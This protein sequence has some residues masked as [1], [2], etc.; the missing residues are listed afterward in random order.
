MY[1]EE[2]LQPP[3]RG[4]EGCRG[5]VFVPNS[6][7]GRGSV[8]IVFFVSHL[9]SLVF[10]RYWIWASRACSC[11]GWCAFTL[12]CARTTTRC[13]ALLRRRT[14]LPTSAY[15]TWV[16]AVPRLD[17]PQGKFMAVYYYVLVSFLCWRYR[18]GRYC[19]DT[20]PACWAKLLTKGAVVVWRCVFDC[21]AN[22]HWTSCALGRF[23]VE[24]G[25]PQSTFTGAQQ[26][27]GV[28]ILPFATEGLYGVG[29]RHPAQP[30]TPTAAQTRRRVQSRAAASRRAG[31]GT[32]R[33]RTCR[34][35][36]TRPSFNTGLFGIDDNDDDCDLP[37]SFSFDWTAYHACFGAT[38]LHVAVTAMFSE[39]AVLYARIAGWVTS[40]ASVPLT[41][42]GA[43]DISRQAE[44]FVLK[45][46]TP[47]LGVV[48][49]LKV[50]KLLRHVMDAI[51]M[52]GN[53]QN[54][55]TCGNEA[56]HKEDKVF[57]R[58][59]NKT[60]ASYTQQMVRQA[61]GSREVL[62][63]INTIDDN[64][65]TA[66][67][68]V[69]LAPTDSSVGAPES[70]TDGPSA[71]DSSAAGSNSNAV[72]HFARTLPRQTVSVLSR[73]PALS[74]LGTLLGLPGTT[75][76]PVRNSLRIAA[77]LDCGSML[78]QIVRAT[79]SFISKPWYDAVLIDAD[80]YRRSAGDMLVG[81][82][83]LL[84]R[85]AQQDMAAV[86]LWEPVPPT[87]G[88]PL[89]ARS[90]TR[91][92]WAAPRSDGG[93]WLVQIVPTSRIRRLVHVVPDFEE[94]VKRRGLDADLPGHDATMERHREMRFFVNSFF[95]WA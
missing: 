50:H 37:P 51:N 79:P 32:A 24:E 34:Q 53:L 41:L 70:P 14:E 1:R 55:N 40:T 95:P 84:F 49:T 11:I 44:H 21:T 77:R 46:V 2:L 62:R 94:L 52:H 74:G 23:L 15:R 18:P 64:M 19:S 20:V 67:P 60:L 13:A 68:A 26:R 16:V 61:Q 30:P 42:D 28:A 38:P 22:Y 8:L 17:Q 3:F 89:A 83:R 12:T 4:Q 73:R 91:L 10:V 54:A 58:R 48:H 27:S 88:C 80:A 63:R 31:A 72:N 7:A 25:K 93:D 71:A 56:Q 43:H 81:E 75:T 5:P 82:V 36:A 87:P 9:P 33:V 6:L 45:I 47:I 76:L 39:Y 86:C 57:Y 35:Q 59:T 66:M 29:R 69:R 90:C 78:S 92:R 85:Q 65:E